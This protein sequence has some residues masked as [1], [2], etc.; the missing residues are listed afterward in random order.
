MADCALGKGTDLAVPS[1][2][3]YFGPASATAVSLLF[4]MGNGEPQ[5][6]KRKTQGKR[7]LM[8]RMNPCPSLNHNPAFFRSL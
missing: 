1:S 6:L 4:A 2:D 5:A 7:A 8:A 3:F